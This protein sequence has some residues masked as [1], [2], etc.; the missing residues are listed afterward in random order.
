MIELLY[1]ST[2]PCFEL[3]SA[4]HF[5]LFLLPWGAAL[6][7]CLSANRIRETKLGRHIKIMLIALFMLQQFLLY[8][9]YFFN[10]KFDFHDALPLYPCRLSAL[11]CLLMLIKFDRKVFSVLYYMGL[12]GATLAL[13]FP[14]TSHL[15][16]PNAMFIQFFIG[17]IGIIVG[18]AYLAI[19]NNY[20]PTR[21]GF[22]LAVR[23]SLLFLAAMAVFDQITHANYAYMAQKPDISALKWMP[24]FPYHIPLL[25]A[26]LVFTYWLV[27]KTSLLFRDRAKKTSKIYLPS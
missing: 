14:D 7:F 19:K 21:E 18:I 23:F 2:R 8:S 17:H 10:G 9:W 25:M 1:F 16:F 11:L 6:W 27:H 15:G 3:F 5:L 26:F 24:D 20:V 4:T 13:L 12:S 22:S